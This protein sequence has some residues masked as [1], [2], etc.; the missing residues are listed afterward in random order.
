MTED[1]AGVTNVTSL[2][3]GGGKHIALERVLDP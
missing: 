2:H 1:A 3:D